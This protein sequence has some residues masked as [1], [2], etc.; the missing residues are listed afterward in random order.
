MLTQGVEMKDIEGRGKDQRM[1]RSRQRRRWCLC[2]KRE[3]CV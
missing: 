1:S 3:A 2:G